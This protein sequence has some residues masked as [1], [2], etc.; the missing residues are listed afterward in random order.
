MDVSKL[1]ADTLDVEKYM[2]AY[3][4]EQ[5]LIR[6]KGFSIAKIPTK[7][8]GES[9]YLWPDKEYEAILL[10]KQSDGSWKFASATVANIDK[11]YTLIEKKPPVFVQKGLLK[12]IPESAFNTFWGLSYFQWGILGI[13]LVLGYV[14][15]K[16]MPFIIV[17]VILKPLQYIKSSEKY[18]E[19]VKRALSPLAYIAALYIWYHGL[20][21]AR[22]APNIQIWALWI[23]HPLGIALTMVAFMRLCDV[24]ALWM[25]GRMVKTLATFWWN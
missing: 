21:L 2:L 1:P 12:Y 25:R 19:L 5:I 22:V 11:N 17:Y 14:V 8:N 7:Y 16:I 24:F 18:Y 4:L 9:Y 15:Y 10:A 20:T 6:L 3:R 13:F 23:I